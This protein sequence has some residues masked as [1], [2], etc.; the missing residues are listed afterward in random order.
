[1]VCTDGLQCNINCHGNGC[2]NLTLYCDD[3]Q[4]NGENCSF[5]IICQN[6]QESIVCPDGFVSDE[7]AELII[8]SS[9]LTNFDDILP[10]I[11]DLSIIEMSTFENGFDACND[12]SMLHGFDSLTNSEHYRTITN[13]GAPDPEIFSCVEFN[14]D[15]GTV[16]RNANTVCC[17]EA[18]SCG[19][20]DDVTVQLYDL[21]TVPNVTT[22]VD[23]INIAIR[24]DGDK[25]CKDVKYDIH[26]IDGGNIYLTG[27]EAAMNVDRIKSNNNNSLGISADIFC[28]G[29]ASCKSITEISNGDNLYCMAK[30][31]CYNAGL[32]SNF[33]NVYFYGDD[34]CYSCNI[35][36]IR[37]NIYCNG[38]RS[39]STA[40]IT[41]I[42]LNGNVYF[43]G[44]L[45]GAGTVIENVE[46]NVFVIGEDTFNSDT[47]L[48]NVNNVKFYF[49]FVLFRI[50]LHKSRLQTNFG[51]HFVSPKQKH[52]LLF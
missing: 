22:V 18:G 12:A 44:Y 50:S 42:N 27:I 4:N 29:I 52:I 33:D 35:D 40:V 16:W 24:C 2:N 31:S 5:N 10:F 3:L 38:E 30:A 36:S 1:M 23:Y 11:P 32:V 15:I 9:N 6:S 25:V 21:A 28:T 34:S 48:T 43:S 46:Q 51:R 8:N 39:C 47:K 26:A 49:V 17:T 45:S 13:C 20:S 37:E 19:G 41:N 14:Y 7:L